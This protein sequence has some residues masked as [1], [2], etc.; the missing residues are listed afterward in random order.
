MRHPRAPPQSCHMDMANISTSELPLLSP[1]CASW[2]LGQWWNV[3]LGKLTSWPVVLPVV[4]FVSQGVWEPANH[5]RTWGSHMVCNQKG[6]HWTFGILSL[7]VCFEGR[8]QNTSTIFESE[9]CSKKCH[10]NGVGVFLFVSVSGWSRMG[11]RSS[12]HGCLAQ[13]WYHT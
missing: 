6:L 9:S 3:C 5:K 2:D 1:M 8:C 11:C 7:Q 4:L 13:F 10:G 12:V